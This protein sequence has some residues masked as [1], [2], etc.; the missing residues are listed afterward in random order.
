MSPPTLPSR[1]SHTS[2]L[3]SA[4]VT[5]F[6]RLRT[7][8]D[9]PSPS[10]GPYADILSSSRADAPFLLRRPAVSPL[11]VMSHVETPST[12]GV[13]RDNDGFIILGSSLPIPRQLV[14][15]ANPTIPHLRAGSQMP[16]MRAP[17][18][19]DVSPA[20]PPLAA[21]SPPPLSSLRGSWVSSAFLAGR[22][23]RASTT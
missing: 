2:L 17:A 18:A 6:L 10:R 8:A 7:R 23:Y 12:C 21:P 11:T 14:L 5:T 22:A 3:H 15:L 20:R 9:I 13:E 1:A 4:R 16:E 19:V